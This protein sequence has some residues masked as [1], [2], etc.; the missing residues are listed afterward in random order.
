MAYNA[1]YVFA[2][3]FYFYYKED[4][5]MSSSYFYDRTNFL[6]FCYAN[7]MFWFIFTINLD[8]NGPFI[9]TF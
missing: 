3:N 2:Y 1:F 9:N 6:P 5:F 7:N 4:Y 8:P